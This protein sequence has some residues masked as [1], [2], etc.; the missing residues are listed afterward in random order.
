MLLTRFQLLT[1]ALEAA[2]MTPEDVETVDGD[3][4]FRVGRCDVLVSEE[5]VFAVGG[6]HY[7]ARAPVSRAKV[8]DSGWMQTPEDVLAFLR[9]HGNRT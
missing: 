8:A 7:L 1:A 2:G 6:F 9:R 5:P 4:T 3:T